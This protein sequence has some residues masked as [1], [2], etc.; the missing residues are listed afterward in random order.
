MHEEQLEKWWIRLC[1]G[2]HWLRERNRSE[3]RFLLEEVERDEG[4]DGRKRWNEE[5]QQA[6]AN[7]LTVPPDRVPQPGVRPAW[8]EAKARQ[9]QLTSR[10]AA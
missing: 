6:A 3:Y 8:D 2:V 9:H 5:V 1:A 4:K 7:G 10:I